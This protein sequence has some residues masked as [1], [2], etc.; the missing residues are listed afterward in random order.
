MINVF[1]VLTTEKSRV[2]FMKGLVYL[3][4]SQE[5]FEGTNE[6][7]PEEMESLKGAMQT[8]N[9]S[10]EERVNI[11]KLIYS[12]EINSDIEFDNIK[13][14][15]FFIREGI[16]ICYVDGIYSQAE[17]DMIYRMG[18]KLGVSDYKIKQIEDWAFEGIQWAERGDNLIV[19][20]D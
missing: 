1:D 20:E 4:K 8:L 10:Q 12:T 3:S 17:K 16:Q 13:Q 14:S 5:I 11:E 9:I 7:S 6:I 18:Q 19:M 15:L 2:N